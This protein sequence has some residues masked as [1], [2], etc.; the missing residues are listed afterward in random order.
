MTANNTPDSGDEVINVNLGEVS[1]NEDQELYKQLVAASITGS[2]SKNKKADGTQRSG[3][4]LNPHAKI[5][6]EKN[7][8]VSLIIDQGAISNEIQHESDELCERG[9]ATKLSALENLQIGQKRAH[10]EVID[11]ASRSSPMSKSNSKVD[12]AKAGETK[13]RKLQ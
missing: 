6:E 3:S 11:I 4:K 13:R 7:G 9:Q 1:Q 10:N 12:D 2:K 8:S 5:V